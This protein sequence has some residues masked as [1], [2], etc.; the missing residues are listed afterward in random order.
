MNE[1]N[2]TKLIGDIS[3][4][5]VSLELLKRKFSVLEPIGDRLPYD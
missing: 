1:K 4:K 5:W 2:D 3:E